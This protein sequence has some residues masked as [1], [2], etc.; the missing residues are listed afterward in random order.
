MKS[1]TSVFCYVLGS[2]CIASLHRYAGQ[3]KRWVLSLS[4]LIQM[5]FIAIASVM[6]RLGKSSGSPVGGGRLLDIDGIPADPGFPWLDLLPIGLLS[7]QAAGKVVASRMLEQSAL[8][9]V[10][11][12]TL[13]SDLVSDPT[14]FSAG[15]WGNVQRNRRISGVVFYFVGAV[16]GGVAASHSIGFSGG[17]A[18]AAAIQFCVAIAWLAW[19]AEKQ[20]DDEE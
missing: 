14:F 2:V 16:F 18:I 17:L 10:V 9:V 7:F 15:L 20:Q 8:P 19:P 1:L 4:F 5:V 3:R 11:L 6:V 13:Y 12:T